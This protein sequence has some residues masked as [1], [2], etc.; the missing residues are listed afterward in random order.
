MVNVGKYTIHGSY[1]YVRN[2][3]FA[4]LVCFQKPEPLRKKGSTGS[5]DRSEERLENGVAR[6]I[7]R[8]LQDQLLQKSN[9]ISGQMK[10]DFTHLVI[11]SDLFGMVK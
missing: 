3:P 4:T 6:L 2:T 7:L 8:E 9:N 5:P 10:K 11:Q 1:G